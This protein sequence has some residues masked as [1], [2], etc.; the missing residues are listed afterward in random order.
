ML[1]F[2]ECHWERK[3]KKFRH[4]LRH[5]MYML[6]TLNQEKEYDKLQEYL[7]MMNGEIEAF[8]K[9]I[10]ALEKQIPK[11][12]THEATLYECCT[13]P[14]CKNV[15]DRFEKWGENTVR[16]TYEYC[17]YCGQKLD[18]RDYSTEKGGKK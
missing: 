17:H 9:A 6:Q 3:T 10:N 12:L 15:I 4:D 1:F 14:N 13:C 8:G 11:R 18:W 5:H 7:E 16:I 2:F